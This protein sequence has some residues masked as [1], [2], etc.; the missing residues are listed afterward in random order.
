[1]E[2]RASPADLVAHTER[3][4]LRRILGG[5]DEFV[6][7][8]MKCRGQGGDHR[9]R[10]RALT[11]FDPPDGGLIE[12]SGVGQLLLG[13]PGC[14]PQLAQAATEPR[15][16]GTSAVGV[17]SSS[18]HG[19]ARVGPRITAVEGAHLISV[20]ENIDDTP[21]GQ[22]L[23]AIM[24]GVAEFEINNL[25]AEALKGMTMKA[26][27][28]GTPG[29][30]PIGYVNQG[31]R[32]DVGEVRTIAVD[33]ERAPIIQW[34]FEACATGEWTIGLLTD[35]LR[36]KGLPSLPTLKRPLP[37]P[38]ERSR[39]Y[40]LLTNPYYVGIVTFGGVQYEGRHQPLVSRQTFDMVQQV[41]RE[42]RFGEQQRTYN[43]YLKGSLYCAICES[44]LCYMRAKGHGGIYEYYFC[45]GRQQKR[46]E[47][48]LPF[49]AVDEVQ[50][51]IEAYWQSRRQHLPLDVEDRVRKHL[52]AELERQR[53][54]AAPE[55]EYARKRVR[56]LADERRRLAE[57]V[58]K[59]RLP[60]DLSAEQRGRIEQELRDAENILRTEQLVG[61]RIDT[62]LSTALSFIDRS[63]EIYSDGSERIRRLA[64]RVF[65]ERLEVGAD[66]TVTGVLRPP[67]G[68]LTSDA[69]VYWRGEDEES[70]DEGDLVPAGVLSGQGLRMTELAGE[71]G[72]EPLI[73]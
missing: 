30:A 39:V 33:P 58:V 54:L 55:L 5:F 2:G 62:H 29:Q 8:S 41:L 17:G 23:H 6:R 3:R 36:E 24:A 22:L 65:F 12:T 72:F 70:R 14:H 40:H 13:E 27:L 35:A 20:K 11:T 57:E 1:M 43:H 34:A 18:R 67:F 71:R 32:I 28:G 47:C 46:T 9:Q 10:R 61:G 64:N 7:S 49:L 69:I 59:G 45:L 48:R 52:T 68:T 15:L 38:I 51:A 60:G 50:R 26:Q 56:E 63:W 25:G 44:R 31:R 66:R 37:K 4:S 53:R 42:H 16:Q 73:G 21:A 19:A